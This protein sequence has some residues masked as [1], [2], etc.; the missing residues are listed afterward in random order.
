MGL[1]SFLHPLLSFLHPPFVIPAYA[2]MTKNKAGVTKGDRNDKER[3][4]C[5]SDKGTAPG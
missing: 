3:E 1:L 2:G 5:R 4:E